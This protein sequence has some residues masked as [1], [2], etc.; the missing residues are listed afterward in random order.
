MLSTI[1]FL[2]KFYGSVTWFEH[3]VL[4]NDQTAD[5]KADSLSDYYWNVYS[6]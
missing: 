2:D 3:V 1:K 5:E 4:D 6:L